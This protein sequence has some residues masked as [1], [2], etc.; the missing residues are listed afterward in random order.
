MV[1]LAPNLHTQ[2]SNHINSLH[3]P[4]RGFSIIPQ[5]SKFLAQYIGMKFTPGAKNNTA[6][7]MKLKVGLGDIDSFSSTIYCQT[8]I[9]IFDSTAI[10]HLHSVY[11]SLPKAEKTVLISFP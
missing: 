9:A 6:D 10:I 7:R 4:P 3:H 1:R 2:T 8:F 5:A 11:V